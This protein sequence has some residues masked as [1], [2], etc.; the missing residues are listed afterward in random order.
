M[1]QSNDSFKKD[2]YYRLL[3]NASYNWRKLLSL[4]SLKILSLL[5]K[6]QDAKLIRVLILDDTVENK[7]GKNIEEVVTTFGVIKQREKSEV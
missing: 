7:V 4:S 3:T 2:V 1:N 5:H 6:V